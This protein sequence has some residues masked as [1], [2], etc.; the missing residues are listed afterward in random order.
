MSNDKVELYYIIIIWLI[1]GNLCFLITYN[2]HVIIHELSLHS[3]LC[4]K[5]AAKLQCPRRALADIG[6]HRRSLSIFF[7]LR[8][9]MQS[10]DSP[11]ERIVQ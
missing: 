1:Y 7:F 9:A 2:F 3:Y 11:R 10:Y 4:F 5:S 6:G 8:L